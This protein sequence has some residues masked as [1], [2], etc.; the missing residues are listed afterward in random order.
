[1]KD[2]HDLEIVLGS[3]LPLLIVQTSEE[4]RALDLFRRL[5]YTETRPMYVWS[6]TE[7]MTTINGDVPAR[8][9]LVDPEALLRH[10]KAV[11]QGG[12]YILLDFH[13]FIDNPI[14]LRLVREIAQAAWV[15]HH[16][17]MVSPKLDTP[18]DLKLLTA[19][20]ELSLPNRETIY[21]II[22]STAEEYRKRYPARKV[23]AD[24]K[25]L[26]GMINQ[27]I[28]LSTPDV[29]RLIH[30]AIFH[31]GA[32]TA[33]DLSEIAKAKYDLIN[34]GEVLSFEYD[35][36]RFEEVG[37]FR[38]LKRWLSHRKDIFLTGKA[39]P[40]LD[41]PKG[42]M[43]LGVQGGGKSLAAK[44]VA[45]AWNVP[46]L[47][48]DFGTLFNKYI[49]ESERNLRVALKTANLMAPCVLWIDE[50]E[51]G[52]A[53]SGDDAGPSRRMLGT[54][55]TWMAER[56]RPVFLVATAND[57][58]RL[59]PELI[60]KGRLDEIFFVDLPAADVRAQIFGIHLDKRKVAR[61][62][63]DFGKL[64][65]SSD[66]FTGAEIEQAVVSALYAAHAQSKPLDQDI[67][68]HELENTRPLSVVMA[69]QVAE[70]RAWAASRTVPAD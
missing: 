40:G 60:R 61:Q 26:D 34:S 56:E 18:P 25:A 4:R 3:T 57:I 29:K 11:K 31:D 7:G 54:L 22:K 6:A 15:N 8:K 39:P 5:T 20:F 28:G 63:F 1:M 33:S 14:L 27:L 43:L 19:R 21:E 32:I 2:L 9:D 41:P 51:K 50:I 13:P 68:T 10:V 65:A 64:A 70:L 55:L 12:I 36:S 38:A 35:T 59:P 44:A 24:R 48:L 62:G 46:L 69:E 45:G 47:R 30:N 16:L 58:S 23:K 53:D 67:L 52:L 17:V 66:G 37:G 49:G 42:L